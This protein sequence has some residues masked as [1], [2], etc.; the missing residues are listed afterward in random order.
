MTDSWHVVAKLL[1]VSRMSKVDYQ[2]K[3][4]LDFY[5]KHALA[6][7]SSLLVLT[8]TVWH[9]VSRS[10]HSTDDSNESERFRI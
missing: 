2:N 8:D 4:L 1:T 6:D 3:V 7:L 10:H 9:R 5:V